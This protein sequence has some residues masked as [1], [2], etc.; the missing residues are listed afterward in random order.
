ME[1]KDKNGQTLRVKMV[2]SKN[3]IIGNFGL[4]REQEEISRRLHNFDIKQQRQR[5]NQERL[6]QEREEKRHAQDHTLDSETLQALQEEM[7]IERL[8][9]AHKSIVKIKKFEET[10]KELRDIKLG[11]LEEV[12]TKKWEQRDAKLKLLTDAERSRKAYINQKDKTRAQTLDAF[13]QVFKE[14]VD[15]KKEIYF[16]KKLDQEE[17]LQRTKNFYVRDTNNTFLICCYA[18]GV[19]SLEVGSKDL[20]QDAKS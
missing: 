8:V 14:D 13:R 3:L 18:I 9:L 2:G 4:Q 6:Q 5:V 16:L 17:N 15:Q 19:V 11:K 12:N 1:K 10:R 7:K 20:E